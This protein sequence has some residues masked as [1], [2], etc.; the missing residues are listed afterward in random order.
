[1]NINE[2]LGR[3]AKQ[4][5]TE[6]TSG[7]SYKDQ[8]P[9][10][11]QL[12]I[13]LRNPP[14]VAK[15]LIHGVL[16]CG[17]KMMISGASKAG[18]TFLLMELSVAIA[19]GGEWL[20]FQCTKGKVLYINFEI[21][22]ASFYQRYGAILKAL[23]IQ[24]QSVENLRV[25]NLRGLNVTLDK[26]VSG[27]NER[28]ENG[29][30]SAIILDP[31]YK[32]QSGD[33]N[34][35]EAISSFCNQIDAICTHT[36]SAVIY[37]HHQSKGNQS[38][39]NAIDRASGS[40]VFARDADAIIDLLALEPPLSIM[41]E[42]YGYPFK[43]ESVLREFKPFKP[44]NIWFKYPLHSLDTGKLLDHAPVSGSSASNLTKSQKRNKK[45]IEDVFEKCKDDSGTATIESIADA[46]GCS[47][48]TV[49]SRVK[50]SNGKY[51]CENGKV[52]LAK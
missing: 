16:R 8:L 19:T 21:A 46:L 3:N 18:K 40:G 38:R 9:P 45:Q 27:L 17:H 2:L 23:K 33:E 15:E 12:D 24:S 7:P 36:G 47:S 31:I 25:W 14:Q 51:I 39:K 26:L 44:I 22:E 5:P 48:R 43:V 34:S 37:C 1:M 20:G 35:A 6:E 50:E 11:K 42:T 49:R 30:Y 32:I 10:F 13:Q 52:Q 41:T 28:M 4:Q 29:E